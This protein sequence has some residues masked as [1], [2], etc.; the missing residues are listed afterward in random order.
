[1]SCLATTLAGNQYGMMNKELWWHPS[2]ERKT[3]EFTSQ[4]NCSY[5]ELLPRPGGSV[6]TPLQGT[7]DDA[8]LEAWFE[9]VMR[10]KSQLHRSSCSEAYTLSGSISSCHTYARGTAFKKNWQ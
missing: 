8:S 9:K 2:G 5:L 6:I 7:L 10:S 1:M 3:V 4:T